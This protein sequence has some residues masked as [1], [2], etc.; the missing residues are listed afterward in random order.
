MS[1]IPNDD[2]ELLQH[3]AIE[4]VSKQWADFLG[5]LGEEFG[6]QLTS[7]E[8]RLL[9]VRIGSRFAESNPLGPCNDVAQ[10]EA[11]MNRVWSERRW[12]F[13]SLSDEG[14]HLTVVHRACPLP[15]ALQ[16]GAEVVGGYL[17]GVYAV[18]LKGAGA[19]HQ[20]TL[21][22]K[23]ASGQNMHMSFELAAR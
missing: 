6:L 11:A 19:P 18:W 23:P 15:A 2:V 4:R 7:D 14:K 5:L 16:M 22:Q 12:G 8:F 3:L 1:D 13:A 21:Q 17:E 10:L 20:L 9:L